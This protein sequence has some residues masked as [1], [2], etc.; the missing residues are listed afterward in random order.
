MEQSNDSINKILADVQSLRD[1]L[2][3]E[4]VIGDVGEKETAII[5]VVHNDAQVSSDGGNVV[6]SG[7]G[8]RFIDSRRAVR[9][10]NYWTSKI[11]KTR[12]S[13]QNASRQQYTEG[14]WSE[15]SDSFPVVTSDENSH[16]DILFPEESVR[17]EIRTLRDE[18][19]YLDFRV[20]GSVSRRHLFHVSRSIEELE[21]LRKPLV[22]EI[23]YAV[24]NVDVFSPLI[25]I[26][27]EMP[28]V[29]PHT[30]FA[31]IEGIKALLDKGR[32]HLNMVKAGLNETRR[33]APSH[34]LRDYIISIVMYIK[35]VGMAFDAAQKVLSSG[36]MQKIKQA[37]EEMKGKIFGVDDIKRKR[38]DIIAKFNISS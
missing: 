11:K 29:S 26:A 34:E 6:F 20:E 31:Y 10:S 8:L 22:V 24:D 36:D 30:T 38:A 33:E 32:Q 19:P 16:G 1:Y 3:S 27:N 15:G 4:V 14:I 18:L 12:P 35:S 21:V 28:S 5:I 9:G 2:K 25:G 23:F 7:V 17:Y 37:V 13:E